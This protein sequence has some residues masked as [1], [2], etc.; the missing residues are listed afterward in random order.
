MN[1]KTYYTNLYSE[2]PEKI[3]IISYD[4]NKN[5]KIIREDGAEDEIRAGLVYKNI[6]MT[7]FL[8]RRELSIL[9]GVDKK[10]IKVGQII[11][12]SQ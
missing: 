10:N 1:K 2:T 5:V 7:K 12:S 11:L 4:N 9:G 3:S 8:S 6:E